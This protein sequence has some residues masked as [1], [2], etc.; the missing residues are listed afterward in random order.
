MAKLV[1]ICTSPKKGM[2]KVNVG[3]GTLV[4]DY[5]IE[6]DAHGGKWHRQVSLLAME[7][8]QKMR[9]KGLDVN[10]G[11]FAENLTTEGIELFTLPIGTRMKIGEALTEVTQ[12][13]KECHS[14]CA[15]YEQAGDCVMPREG[16]FVRVH[17]D[18]HI[19][20]ESEIEFYDYITV[21][22][23][24]A[25]DKGSTG[26]RQD[27]CRAVIEEMLPQIDGYTLEYK[28]VPDD[29]EA[30]EATI[31]EWADE[32][33]LDLILISGGTGFAPRDV[34]PEAVKNVITK[35]VPGI[36]EAM[37]M[38][39]MSITDRSM[40]SR[41]VAGIREKSLIIALPGSPKAVGE[42]LPV[43]IPVLPHAIQMVRGVGSECAAKFAK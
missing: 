26:E 17:K 40:L 38:G 4:R 39:T 34:T 24:I 37:R 25:S 31:K 8:V 2:R 11:D 1:A 14:H 41:S 42:F 29:Q 33:K 13:G 35:E 21:G 9:D 28:I 22:I 18:A 20:L 36:P 43:I 16:I 12:I 15:I 6:G 27:G 23:L 7:S 5:G 32:M 3:E 30:L 19:T 10:P